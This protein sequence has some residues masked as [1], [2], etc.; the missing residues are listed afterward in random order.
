MRKPRFTAELIIA[1]LR[2]YEAGAATVDAYGGTATTAGSLGD[3]DKE[4]ALRTSHRLRSRYQEHP[5]RRLRD[6]VGVRERVNLLLQPVLGSPA[7]QM[8]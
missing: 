3:D 4:L 8:Q 1:I 5:P 7:G 6:D 2:E